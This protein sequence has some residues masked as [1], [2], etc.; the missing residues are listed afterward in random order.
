VTIKHGE[1]LR[2]GAVIAYQTSTRKYIEYQNDETGL[3][4]KAILWDNVDA[5]DGDVPAVAIV[6]DAEVNGTELQWP[7]T[8]DTGDRT[9]AVTDLAL[10]GIVVRRDV[11][12]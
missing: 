2:A 6:R 8:E 11:G 4:A 1:V 9:A 5:T 12:A 10:V 3:A 7:A